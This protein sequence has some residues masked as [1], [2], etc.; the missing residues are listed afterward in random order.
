MVPS[1]TPFRRIVVLALAAVLPITGVARAD[2]GGLKPAA[3]PEFGTV[4][5]VFENDVF[6]DTDRDYTNGVRL[7]YVTGPGETPA[8]ALAAARRLPFFPG[9][10]TI[11]TSY[12]LGQNM[13]T[14]SDITVDD[15]PPGQRPYAGWLYGSIGLIAEWGERLERLDQLELSLGVVGPP[16]LAEPVQ[17]F[18]HRYITHSPDPRGWERQLKTEPAV[19]LTWQRSWRRFL[20]DSVSDLRFDVVPHAGAAV[21]NVFTHADAGLTLRVGNDLPLDYGPPRI[22][23]S[24]PGAGFFIPPKTLRWYLFAGVEGRAVARNIFLDG[25]TFAVSRSVDKEPLVGD[26]QFGF[27]VTWRNARLSYTHVVRTPEYEGQDG[28]KDFGALGLSVRF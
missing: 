20:Y 15:P 19:V 4:S 2:D 1:M 6:Y 14:P 13:Y 24:L 21:G 28:D 12:A 16:S 10:A 18:V 25:N 27:A 22:Q 23:P 26:L 17:R 5:L 3:N 9:D 8:W 11:R 7:S